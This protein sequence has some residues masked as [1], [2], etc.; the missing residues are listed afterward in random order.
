MVDQAGSPETPS[1]QPCGLA[2]IALGVGALHVVS[3]AGRLHLLVAGNG[4]VEPNLVWK[5]A[6]LADR[7]DGLH[8]SGRYESGT[9]MAHCRIAEHY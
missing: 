8:P 2:R 6:V 9:W 7:G 4:L 3:T 5:D 1:R